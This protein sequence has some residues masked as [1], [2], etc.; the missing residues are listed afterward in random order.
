MNDIY[1]A[2]LFR[3]SVRRYAKAKLDDHI[4]AKVQAIVAASRPLCPGNHLE[5]QFHNVAPDENLV[6]RL[7]GYGRIV[8]PPHYLAPYMIGD[9]HPL[10]DLG[11]RVEQIVVRLTELGIGSCYI[12]GLGREDEVRERFE[13][14]ETSRIG[15]FLAFGY[16]ATSLMGRTFNTAARRIAGATNKLPLERI[17]YH[18]TFE[19]PSAPPHELVHLMEA[20]RCAPSAANAQPWRFLWR[21]DELYLFVQRSNRRYGDG[22]AADYRYY[23]GGICMAN[24]ALALE[25]MGTKGQWQMLTQAHPGFPDHL[26]ELEPLAKLLLE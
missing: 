13:L 19:N 17:F 15:A 7:G 5:I 1:Q 20:A 6:D 3:R 22:P 8:S 4:L 23:D 10:V 21:N 11:F 18:T 25:A 2:I 24:V 26:P 16:P 9:V 14:P 12:G